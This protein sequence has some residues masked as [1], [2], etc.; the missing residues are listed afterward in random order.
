MPASPAETR[1]DDL[2][3]CR[4][5]LKGGSRS[6]F[7]ASFLLPRDMAARATA[8][9]AFCRLAD[10]AVDEADGTAAVQ[11]AILHFR[12]RV[13]LIFDGHPLD[14]PADRAF[15][16]VAHRFGLART[17]VDALIEGFE[18]DAAGR[19]YETIEDLH[20]YG[21]RVAGC[22]GVMMS[23]VMERT[24]GHVLARAADLGVAMQLTN[25][26]RDVGEDARNGRLYLPLEWLRGEGISPEGFLADPVFSPAL[27]RVIARVLAEAQR[28]YERADAGLDLL[29]AGCR[30]GI[31]AARLLYA[32]IGTK[33][34]AQGFD[35]VSRRATT[36]LGE[37]LPLLARALFGNAASVRWL[38]A[39]PL[40]A[41]AFLVEAGLASRVVAAMARRSGPPP[42]WN[43]VARTV[44]VIDMF[45][46]LERLDRAGTRPP[47]RAMSA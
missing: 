35:S 7:A 17:V 28:L 20:A 31:R 21:A 38:K 11:D 22:V 44:P 30:P 4:A 23:T 16:A 40:A 32:A 36:S 43:P 33:V 8:L 10:D 26:A 34:A 27:G 39:P 13:D 29:P 3:A 18:W 41:T 14:H 24:E 15:A 12:Q 37:K 42:W 47:R 19:T 9:Y 46:R 45:A 25:I 2:A 1:A 5:L 6:F